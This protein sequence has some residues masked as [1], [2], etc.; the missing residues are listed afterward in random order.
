[1][2][3]KVAKFIGSGAVFVLLVGASISVMLPIRTDEAAPQAQGS[4][5]N[6]QG[7]TVDGRVQNITDA[8][9]QK[10]VKDYKAPAGFI[11]VMSIRSGAIVAASNYVEGKKSSAIAEASTA[12]EVGSVMKPLL[13]AAALNEGK[14]T[15]SF[16]Y[17]DADKVTVDGRTIVN[18]AAHGA[19]HKSLEDI[20]VLSLNTGA[21]H[22]LQRMGGDNL[23]IQTRGLWHDYLTDRYNFGSARFWAPGIDRVGTVPP[24]G[25]PD[26]RYRYAQTAFGIGLTISPAQ[27]SA[28]YAAIVGDGNYR[29]PFLC[30]DTNSTLHKGSRIMSQHTVDSMRFL[31]QKAL[32]ASNPG[33]SIPGHISGGKSGT[34]PIAQ[35]Y[36]TYNPDSNNGTYIGYYGKDEPEYILLVRLTNPITPSYASRAAANVWAQ[37]VATLTHHKVIQ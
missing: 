24:I 21:V 17:Y 36:G 11:M 23:G 6:A 4:F 13:V 34:A 3:R 33:G 19:G 7:T 5:C 14:I 12:Y 26:A 35:S 8:T 16:S 30:E 9:L 25:I 37:L 27:L 18:A 15:P 32:L 28:A 22:V 10:A 20:I 31:L 2:R 29:R 1:M